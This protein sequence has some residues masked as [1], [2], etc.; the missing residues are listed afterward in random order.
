MG[1]SF[2]GVTAA[3]RPRR[4]RADYRPAAD[5]LV[6]WARK[7]AEAL[8][9]AAVERNAKAERAQQRAARRA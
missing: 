1:Y 3:G 5:E 8:R 7:E 4:V 6:V 9:K 2:W